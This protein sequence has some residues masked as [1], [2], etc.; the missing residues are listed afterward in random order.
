MMDKFDDMESSKYLRYFMLMFLFILVIFVF[1]LQLNWAPKYPVTAEIDL[2]PSLIEVAS[3]TSG[4]IH[5]F[6]KKNGDY[7][8]L[9]EQLMDI[10]HLTYR[11]NQSFFQKKEEY[12]H[13]Q[14]HKLAH[15]VSYLLKRYHR[16][17]PLVEKKILTQ[18]YLHQHWSELNAHQLKLNQIQHELVLLNHKKISEIQSP[19]SGTLLYAYIRIGDKVEK[20]QPLL[21][22]QMPKAHWRAKIDVP[23]E[24]RKYLKQQS[25]FRFKLPSVSK[26]SSYR[27]EAHLNHILPI[28]Q[29]NIIQVIADIHQTQDQKH[30]F[31]SKM[32]L[33]G[34]LIGE[35]QTILR[36]LINM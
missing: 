30:P 19:T 26:L 3:P 11:I 5:Q 14:K 27:I 8:H 32:K 17:K 35:Q 16:L 12:L 28:T 4:M 31:L 36:W 22:I 6:S 15:E 24:Y 20:G 25:R 21:V 18:D 33:Q 2:F 7:I 29:S 34:Y 10:E 13:S 1:V 23:I 9:G